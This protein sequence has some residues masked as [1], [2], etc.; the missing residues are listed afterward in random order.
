MISISRFLISWSYKI[1]RKI[2]YIIYSWITRS[3]FKIKLIANDV[4]YGKAL[5]CNGTPYISVKKT[6][7][8]I[9]GNNVTINNGNHFNRI[10]RNQN[11]IFNVLNDAQCYIGN[12]VGLSSAAIVCALKITIEDNVFMEQTLGLQ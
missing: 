1:L 7:S 3:L 9:F 11:C 12:N 10:G 8:L 4:K 5:I 2:F 6:G